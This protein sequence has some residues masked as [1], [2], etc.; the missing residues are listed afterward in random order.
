MKVDKVEEVELVELEP[1]KFPKSYSLEDALGA[2]NLLLL[3]SL[4]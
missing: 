3:Y 4:D 1:T 2:N